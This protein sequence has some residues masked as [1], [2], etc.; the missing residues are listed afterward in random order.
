MNKS[1]GLRTTCTMRYLPPSSSGWTFECPP[2][3]SCSAAAAVVNSEGRLVHSCD[4]T[5]ALM[6]RRNLELKAKFEG[7]SSYYTFKRLVPGAVSVALIGSTCTTLPQRWRAPPWRSCWRPTARVP[8]KP[9]KMSPIR[10]P[11]CW[12]WKWEGQQKS[13]NMSFNTSS[14]CF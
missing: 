13:L 1:S 8:H 11:G 6:K 12:G 2:L 9:L 4:F 14:S 3:S 5:T 7:D 10:W